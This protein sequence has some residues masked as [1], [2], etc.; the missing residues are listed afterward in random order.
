[1]AV[2]AQLPHNKYGWIGSGRLH[3]RLPA[4]IG[5]PRPSPSTAA[6][7]PGKGLAAFKPVSPSIA[8]A[9]QNPGPPHHTCTS[10]E[11]GS[12]AWP[13]SPPG[14]PAGACGVTGTNMP[15]P[16]EEVQMQGQPICWL[17]A[18][19]KRDGPTCVE[20]C[21]A[22]QAGPPCPEQ[23]GPPARLTLHWQGAVGRGRP[24]QCLALRL[25]RQLCLGGGFG[26]HQPAQL[27]ERRSHPGLLSG[28]R[29]NS[30]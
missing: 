26:R 29:V 11:K 2:L 28:C 15:A 6:Q 4:V 24:R 7:L 20:S 23:A 16:A 21:A 22:P 30:S 8:Q 9:C 25:A 27:Q 5:A 18:E 10:A 3:V 12:S 17:Q 14:L 13:H 19:S 1:M